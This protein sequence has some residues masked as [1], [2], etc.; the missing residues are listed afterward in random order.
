[1]PEPEPEPEPE[2]CPSNLQVAATLLEYGLPHVAGI[3]YLDQDDQKM[4]LLREGSVVMKLEQCGLDR[5]QRFSFFDQV[6]T[7]GMD[8]P[9]PLGARAAL[10][11]GKDMTFRDFAQGAFRSRP[12]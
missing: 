11:L 2:L 9:Q 5:A 6:H 10:T 1:M 3:V 7:T 12:T 4:I 8:I